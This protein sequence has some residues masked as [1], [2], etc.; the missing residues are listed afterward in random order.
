MAKVELQVVA[1]A[2]LSHVEAGVSSPNT[3]AGAH[4]KIVLFKSIGE[5]GDLTCS[6]H[7]AIINFIMLFEFAV[8]LLREVKKCHCS[9][10]I[11]H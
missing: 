8:T 2:L 5:H 6:C 11:V 1:F 10:A 9:N 7:V 4:T 3:L